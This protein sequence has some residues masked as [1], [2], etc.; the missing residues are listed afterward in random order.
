[1]RQITWGETC[2]DMTGK[3]DI[4]S[5]DRAIRSAIFCDGFLGFE[6]DRRVFFSLEANPVPKLEIQQSPDAIVVI[7]MSG[8]VLVEQSLDRRSL[9]EFSIHAARVQ[10]QVAD[11]LQLRTFKPAA[12]WGRE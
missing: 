8:F 5:D 7:D 4:Y 2:G 3:I 1:M 10:Q 6:C 9:E 12:P 11:F